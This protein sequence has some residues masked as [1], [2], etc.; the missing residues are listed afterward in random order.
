MQCLSILT[1]IWYNRGMSAKDR[2]HDAVKNSLIKDGWTITHDPYKIKYG[3]DQVYVDLAAER[4]IAAERSGSRILVEVKSFT[5]SST[6]H[7][8]KIAVGQFIMY[9]S[10]LDELGVEDKLYIAVSDDVYANDFNR[11]MVKLVI[12]R[13]EIPLLVVALDS[14]EVIEWTR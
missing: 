11:D 6:L 2:I 3:D 12:N 5:G 7:D 10:V 14:E 8:L 1:I 4:T 13:N 9:R